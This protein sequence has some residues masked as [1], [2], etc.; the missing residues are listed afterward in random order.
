[1]SAAVIVLTIVVCNW[2]LGSRPLAL[3]IDPVGVDL[4]VAI[5]GAQPRRHMWPL[6][7]RLHGA[8]VLAIV[9]AASAVVIFF[10]DSAAPCLDQRPPRRLP[11][12]GCGRIV[13]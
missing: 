9:R 13:L 2:P 3:F 6:R 7:C 8:Y 1:M 11:A 10:Q 12:C 4:F 5:M